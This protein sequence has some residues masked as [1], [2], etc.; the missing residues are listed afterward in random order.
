VGDQA[1]FEFFQGADDALESSSDISEVGGTTTDDEY[2]AVRVR[3]ATS[4][5][6]NCIAAH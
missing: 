5:K 4:D 2:F 3:R 1:I 6:I